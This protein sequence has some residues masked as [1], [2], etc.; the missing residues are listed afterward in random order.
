MTDEADILD[1]IVEVVQDQRE[2]LKYDDTEGLQELM[3]ELQELLFEAKAQGLLRERLA[4]GLAERLNCQPSVSALSAALP[5]ADRVSFE[6]AAERLTQSVFNLKAEMIILNGLI[7][8]SERFSSMLLSEWRRIQGGSSA[9]PG[10]DF[11]G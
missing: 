5:E 10:L 6:S 8:Q 4:N 11:R 2:A 1:V 9:A 3:A 7:E